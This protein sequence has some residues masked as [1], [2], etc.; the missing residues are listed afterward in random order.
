MKAAQGQDRPTIIRNLGVYL[1]S[2]Y[3]ADFGLNG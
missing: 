1:I 3:Y 2:R